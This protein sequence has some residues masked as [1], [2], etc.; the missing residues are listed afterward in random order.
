MHASCCAYK[1]FWLC[2]ECNCMKGESRKYVSNVAHMVWKT[3]KK[4]PQTTIPLR[5]WIQLKVLEW[6]CQKCMG[7]FFDR[8]YDILMNWASH[9][10]KLQKVYQNC[11]FTFKVIWKRK[12]V[13]YQS[14]IVFFHTGKL[15]SSWVLVET[16]YSDGF[17][18]LHVPNF[19][20]SWVTVQIEY[21]W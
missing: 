12:F 1:L 18:M 7:K 21:D 16:S 6:P 14:L 20:R 9:I 5:K 3:G 19:I 10:E 2:Y 8:Y 15:V 11:M 17:Y 13:F 4:L